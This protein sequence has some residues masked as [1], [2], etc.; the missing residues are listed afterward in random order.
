MSC[1]CLYILDTGREARTLSQIT[2]NS[3]LLETTGSRLGV[4]TWVCSA[5]V[6]AFAALFRLPA[7]KKPADSG[8]L[9]SERK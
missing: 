1:F 8:H 9:I 7:L 6:G 2:T 3:Q 5:T 4:V